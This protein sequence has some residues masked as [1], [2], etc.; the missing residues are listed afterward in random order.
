LHELLLQELTARV[1]VV[2]VVSARGLVDPWAGC[3]TSY[4]V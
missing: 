1:E 3:G 2:L 4:S